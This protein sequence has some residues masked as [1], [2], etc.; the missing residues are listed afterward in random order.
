MTRRVPFAPIFTVSSVCTTVHRNRVP[1]TKVQYLP[2]YI[3]PNT[4]NFIF[5][6]NNNAGGRCSQNPPDTGTQNDYSTSTNQTVHYCS[7]DKYFI[8]FIILANIFIFIHIISNIPVYVIGPYH[9]MVRLLQ[10]DSNNAPLDC[11]QY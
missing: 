2:R 1:H 3:D 5:T 9:S 4:P 10:M 8:I 6:C 7:L 11:V